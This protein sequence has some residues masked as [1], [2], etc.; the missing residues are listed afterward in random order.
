LFF[1]IAIINHG[2][3][4]RIIAE[5]DRSKQERALKAEIKRSYEEHPKCHHLNELAKG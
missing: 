2:K 4:E 3:R 5:I 1:S